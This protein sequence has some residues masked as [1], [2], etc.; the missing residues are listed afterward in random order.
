MGGLL[1]WLGRQRAI[2]ILWSL[3]LVA[4][5]CTIERADVRTPSG[6][7][8]EADTTRVRKVLDAIALGFE[9]GE[10]SALDT[11]YH[12]SVTVYEGG[13]AIIGWARYRDER[14]VPEIESLT[15]RHLRFEDVTIRLVGSTAWI[16]CRYTRTA[17]RDGED[18]AARGV[19][20]LIFR[21]LA[22]RWRLVHSHTSNGGG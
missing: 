2:A 4:V 21:K 14:L 10:L 13:D 7:P 9:T 1:I 18:H 12:D 11:I 15:D 6:E 19:A 22:G 16:T 20:T 5:A 8:P 17:I 3:A